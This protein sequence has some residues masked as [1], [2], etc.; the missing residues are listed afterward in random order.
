MEEIKKLMDKHDFF[1]E[2]SDDVRS[3]R[4]GRLEK[5]EIVDKMKPLSK[6]E[7]KELLKRVPVQVMPEWMLSFPEEDL[8]T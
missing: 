4:K 7:Q 6:E 2:F 3:W 1:Y 5:E 8:W